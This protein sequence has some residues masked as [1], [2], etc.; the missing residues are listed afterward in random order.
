MDSV[1]EYLKEAREAQGMSLDQVA[2]LTRIQLQFLQALEDEDFVKLPEHVFT[3]GFVR[4]YARSLGIDEDE[5]LRRFSET[6][7]SFYEKDEDDRK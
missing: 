2:S 4:T 6:A 3:K 7:G 1:G 5:A